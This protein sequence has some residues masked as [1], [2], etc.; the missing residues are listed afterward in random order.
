M[1]PTQFAELAELCN[2]FKGRPFTLICAPSAQ[3]LGQEL[4]EPTRTHALI[5][6]NLQKSDGSFLILERLSVNGKATHP[7]FHFLKRYSSLYSPIRGKS[8]PIPWNFSKFL[9]NKEGQVVA[10]RGPTKSALDLEAEIQ[11]IVSN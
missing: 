5:I 4:P 7:M 9:V 6:N 10:F 11:R 1:A 2:R 8:M 3:F